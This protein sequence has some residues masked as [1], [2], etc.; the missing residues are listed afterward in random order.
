MN[1]ETGITI[2]GA[3][4]IVAAVVLA[5]VLIWHLQ[6]QQKPGPKPGPAQEPNSFE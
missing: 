3:L 1:E 2:L 5:G 6:K 4:G